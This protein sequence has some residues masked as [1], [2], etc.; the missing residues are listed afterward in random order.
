MIKTKGCLLGFLKRCVYFL[1]V[2]CFGVTG[3]IVS[4]ES[5][6]LSSSQRSVRT[7]VDNSGRF[8]VITDD[9]TLGHDFLRWM[10]ITTR[11]T[12]NIIGNKIDLGENKII[13]SCLNSPLECGKME[14]NAENENNANSYLLRLVNPKL[15][16]KI[17]VE[18]NFVTLLIACWAEITGDSITLTNKIPMWLTDGIIQNFSQIRKAYNSDLIIESWEDGLVPSL[19]IFIKGDFSAGNSIFIDK[20]F[21]SAFSGLIIKWIASLPDYSLRF[22]KIKEGILENKLHDPEWFAVSV[23]GEKTLPDMN[24][25]WDKWL[26]QQKQ[27]IYR[28]GQPTARAV[29]NLKSALVVSPGKDGIPENITIPAGTGI[30]WLVTVRTEEW[31]PAFVSYKTTSI[32]LLGI[33]RGKEMGEAVDYICRFLEGLTNKKKTEKE[34]ARYLTNAFT[35]IRNLEAKTGNDDQL[36]IMLEDITANMV[37]EN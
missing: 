16:K 26:L 7:L 14:F 32:R 1:F 24:D 28:P 36:K 35:L 27:I 8:H 33:G 11:K 23:T 21:Q 5:S 20:V 31:I 3:E 2:F 30:D 25:S 22:Q 29:Q 6:S 10:E 9:I 34:L 12:E 17:D 37:E 13:L 4:E 18:R 19:S 15:I